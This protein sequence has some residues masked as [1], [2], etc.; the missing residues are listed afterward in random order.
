MFFIFVI[1][2]PFVKYMVSGQDFLSSVAIKRLRRELQ[3]LKKEKDFGI[4]ATVM[5][6]DNGNEDLSRWEIK[7]NGCEDSLYD[8]YI[9]K[10]KVSFPSRYP[11]LPPSFIFTT[12]MWHPNVYKDG[13]V[14]ISILHTAD[15]AVV[16]PGIL[17][18]SW[19][20]VQSVRTICI[21]ILSMLN[22]P[23]IDSPANVD[24]SVQYRDKRNEYE[25]YVKNLLEKYA[26]KINKH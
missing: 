10:A 22:E 2:Y 5:L 13:R 3:Q 16:D 6:D 26:E 9:L 24:A 14:C 21:S 7:I 8:G 18:C 20:A 23:N 25:M 11:N 12:P 15:E 17:D 4:D 1:F 19:T